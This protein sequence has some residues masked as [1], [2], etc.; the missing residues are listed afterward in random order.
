M[1]KKRIEDM[2]PAEQFEEARQINDEIREYVHSL[3]EIFF[4]KVRKDHDFTVSAKFDILRR[5]PSYW[6]EF[7]IK[8]F[9]RLEK[10]ADKLGY[11]CSFGKWIR[12][13]EYAWTFTLKER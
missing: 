7:L 9:K 10:Y 11:N 8:R 5:L 6:M 2:T 4:E 1:A 13:K 3:T 12:T